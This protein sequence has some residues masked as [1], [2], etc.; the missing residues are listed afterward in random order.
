VLNVFVS[1]DIEGISG[2]VHGDF[3]MPQRSDYLLGRRLMTQDANAAIQGLVEGGAEFIL[4]NDGHGPMRNI[5][6][7][8]LHPAAHLVSGSGDAKD[9]CQLEGADIVKFD[10]AVCIGYHA[11]AGTV[12]AIHPHTIAG[13]VVGELRLNGRPHGELG[14]NAAILGSLGIPTI[15]VSG[16]QA[17]AE[18][19]GDFLPDMV[20]KVEVKRATGRNAAICR[21]LASAREDITNAARRAVEHLGSMGT[22]CPEPPWN[23]DVSFVTL[24][25]WERAKRT[26]GATALDPTTIRIQGENPWEQYRN[27]WACIRS[28]LYEPSGWLG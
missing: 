27:L 15:M 12:R 16:D 1:V 24:A 10:A 20:E 8:D 13:G 19:A 25:Q 2:V 4:V 11:M 7:E 5:L 6:I 21:P 17:L 9:Y 3:M 26:Q 23:L 28:G 18:E 14:L 22:Y